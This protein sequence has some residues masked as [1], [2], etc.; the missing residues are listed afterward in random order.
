MTG[1]SPAAIHL[2]LLLQRERARVAELRKAAQAVVD[3][4]SDYDGRF[5]AVD[6]YW[7]ENLKNV[8]DRENEA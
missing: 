7:F 3:D 4:G 8:L 2:Q 5:T 1:Q 6:T